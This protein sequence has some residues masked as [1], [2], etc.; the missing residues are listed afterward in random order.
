MPKDTRYRNNN[1][2]VKY[3]TF[4]LYQNLSHLKKWIIIF[5]IWKKK[6]FFLLFFDNLE[7]LDVNS[8]L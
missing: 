3:Y 8:K 5:L 2:N 7:H 6:D 4:K 1:N